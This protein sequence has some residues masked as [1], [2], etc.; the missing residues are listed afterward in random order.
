MDRRQLKTRAAIFK[1]FSKLLAHKKY[2]KITVQEIINEADIGRS[3][4]YSH[5]ETKDELLKQLCC[6]IFAHVFSEELTGEA[7]HDF[8]QERNDLKSRLTHIL[9]HLVDENQNI[10]RILLGESKELFMQYFKDYLVELFLKYQEQ[11]AVAI[12]RDFLI[13]YLVGSFAETVI[14]WI[15]NKMQYSPEITVEYYLS[16]L[17]L[18]NIDKT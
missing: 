11:I 13:N 2:G 14:W 18:G 3:T 9:Y 15:N 8:S 10:G 12:P 4:F 1:A 16:L 17:A 5:F 7:T 6:D